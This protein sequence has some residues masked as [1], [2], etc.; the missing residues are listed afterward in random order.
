MPKLITLFMPKCVSS[1]AC[2]LA[3]NSGNLSDWSSI[4][5]SMAS[6]QGVWITNPISSVCWYF[7]FWSVLSITDTFTKSKNDLNGKMINVALMTPPD[8]LSAHAS[9][10]NICWFQNPMSVPVLLVCLGPVTME[11][12]VTTVTVMLGM[13]EPTVGQVWTWWKGT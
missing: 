11:W 12:L 2:D 1:G 10:N 3:F 9:R 4:W 13:R 6:Y 7:L 8:I 5:A